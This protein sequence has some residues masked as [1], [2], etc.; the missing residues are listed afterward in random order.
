MINLKPYVKAKGMFLKDL[1][2][3]TGISVNMIYAFAHHNRNTKSIKF[4]DIDL[5][6]DALNITP[7]E[8]FGYS[9]EH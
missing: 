2:K 6:C 1:A 8:L 7:N 5:I 4:K 9:G 3:E